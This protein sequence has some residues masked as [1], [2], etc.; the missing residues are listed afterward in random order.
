MIG[1]IPQGTVKALIRLEHHELLVEPSRRR[2]V[3]QALGE[4]IVKG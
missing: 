3:D 4:A 1:K 2:K